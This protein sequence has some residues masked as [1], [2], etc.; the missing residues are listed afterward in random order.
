MST[1]ATTV[2]ENDEIAKTVQRY[3]DGGKSGQGTDMKTASTPT[4]RSSATSG[5][6]CSQAPSRTPGVFTD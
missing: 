1:P 5:P 2:S 6:S 4:R 3:V